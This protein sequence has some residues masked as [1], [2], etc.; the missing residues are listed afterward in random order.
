MSYVR[1]DSFSSWEPLQAAGEI[2]I[3]SFWI[4]KGKVNG[5]SY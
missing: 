4:F 2:T 1:I 3:D 5:Q